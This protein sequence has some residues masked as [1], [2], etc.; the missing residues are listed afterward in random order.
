MNDILDVM[1]AQRA[2]RSYDP[3]VPV[4]DTDVERI[5]T[6]ATRAPSAENTQPWV[7][8]VVRSPESREAIADLWSAGWQHAAADL[9]QALPSSLYDDL[10]TG[11]GKRGFA[12]APVVIVVGADL[13]RVMESRAPSSIYPAVQNML[14]AAGSLGWGSCLTTGLTMEAAEHLKAVVGLPPTVLPMATVYVGAPARPLKPG[15]RRPLAEVTHAER[16]GSAWPS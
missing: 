11:I 9:K 7:F 13:E 1:H 16:F 12:D 6:A 8:V 15:R 2:C 10:E 5:L 14:L 4:P 3:T